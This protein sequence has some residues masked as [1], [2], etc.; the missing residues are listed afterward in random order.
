MKSII[1]YAL[2]FFLIPLYYDYIYLNN[3][4]DLVIKYQPLVDEALSHEISPSEVL[5]NQLRYICHAGCY[6]D[7][8]TDSIYYSLQSI[9]PLFYSGQYLEKD[10]I[11]YRI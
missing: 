4:D 6:L 10:F 1:V 3:F 11:F 5:N 7:I 9:K 2:I 8:E